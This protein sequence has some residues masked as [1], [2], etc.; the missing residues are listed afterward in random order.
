MS[1]VHVVWVLFSNWHGGSF[2]FSDSEKTE[3][4]V[5]KYQNREAE[6]EE[7]KKGKMRR[8]TLN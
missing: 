7:R 8:E 2:V 4:S 3:V 5:P 6:I 1:L